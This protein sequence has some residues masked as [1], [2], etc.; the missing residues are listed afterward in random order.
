M[1][2]VMVGGE[3]V[4]VLAGGGV[5][6][7]HGCEDREEERGLCKRE[8]ECCFVAVECV[9]QLEAGVVDAAEGGPCEAVAGARCDDGLEVVKGGAD[10]FV[11]RSRGRRSDGVDGKHGQDDLCVGRVW[12]DGQELVEV[13][14]GGSGMRFD[15]GGTLSAGLRGEDVEGVEEGQLCQGG[16]V[17]W[18]KVCCDVRVQLDGV[19]DASRVLVDEGDLEEDVGAGEGRGRGVFDCVKAVVCVFVSSQEAEES[20]EAEED[21]GAEVVVVCVAEDGS[22]GLCGELPGAKGLVHDGDPVPQ[23]RV[24]DVLQGEDLE[25]LLVGLERRAQRPLSAL[26]EVGPAQSN[27]DLARTLQHLLVHPNQRTRVSIHSQPVLT[28]LFRNTPQP[29]KRGDR[30]HGNLNLRCNHCRTR[31]RAGKSRGSD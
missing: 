18:E 14:V 6:D 3:C 17:V 15:L 25:G 26:A 16:S 11:E 9:C 10:V 19:V 21:D 31:G 23:A 30:R 2:A 29:A 4:F 5:D 7:G 20:A 22:V 27:P 24:L 12:L 28:Q 13:G 8:S 1:L